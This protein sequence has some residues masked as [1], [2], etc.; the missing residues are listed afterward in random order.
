[1]KISNLVQWFLVN[2]LRIQPELV[3]PRVFPSLLGD[4][5]ELWC[6]DD[7]DC[8]SNDDKLDLIVLDEGLWSAEPL[9]SPK[10]TKKAT[11]PK[12]K[13]VKTKK[14]VGKKAKK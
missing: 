12:K 4:G 8:C 5:G 7:L 14:L 13:S 11:K 3:E 2:V 10:K 6:T 9:K 1:M